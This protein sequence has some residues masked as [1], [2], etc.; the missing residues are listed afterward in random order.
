[1][2]NV[3]YITTAKYIERK[4]NLEKQIFKHEKKRDNITFIKTK[5]N[6]IL[7]NARAIF[8]LDTL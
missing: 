7:E 8:Q 1:M 3:N 2:S 5:R 4:T 6:K